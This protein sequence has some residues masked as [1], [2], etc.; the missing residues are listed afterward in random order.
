MNKIIDILGIVIGLGA[1]GGYIVIATI[2]FSLLKRLTSKIKGYENKKLFSNIS[3]VDIIFLVICFTCLLLSIIPSTSL[4]STTI[5]SLFEKEEYE[6]KYYVYMYPEKS[7][8]ENY[9]LEADIISKMT[10]RGDDNE[11]GYFI[12]KVYFPNGGYITFYNSI[13]WESLRIGEKIRTLDDK[14]KYWDIELTKEKVKN[15]G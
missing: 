12:E 15:K 5:G 3:K 1:L 14:E 2:I 9:K 4:G 10:S 11:R 7:Q 8:S 13:G 6:E